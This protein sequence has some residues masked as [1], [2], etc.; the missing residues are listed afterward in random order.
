MSRPPTLTAA[1]IALDEQANLA[2]LL[3]R[4]D[5]VDE[6]VVVDG[7]SRDDTAAVAR[8]HGCRVI[9]RPMDDFASQRNCALD[10]ARGDWVLSID[11]DERPGPGLAAEIRRRIARGAQAAYRVPIRSWIFGGRVRRAGTQDD[12]PVRL[13]LRG[14]A[15]WQGPVHERLQVEGRI[16]RTDAWLVHRTLPNLD[17]FLAKMH[18]Y[19]RIEARARVEAGRAPQWRDAWLA[20]AREFLRRL[21]WKQG[22]LDGPHAWA[23]CALSGLSEWVLAREHR[24]LWAECLIRRMGQSQRRPADRAANV[25]G[26]DWWAGAAL[27]PPYGPSE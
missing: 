6:I 20:P 7:G 2:D 3:P 25:C 12:C 8:R 13:W 1:I 9:A 18:R 4:L 11:A 22:A 19:T 10:H 15:R 27:V 23:F 21:V 16:G 17:A 24:R 26:D 5:W 14:W